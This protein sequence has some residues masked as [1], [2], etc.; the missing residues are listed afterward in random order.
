MD[1]AQCGAELI[2]YA[3]FYDVAFSKDT[4]SFIDIGDEVTLTGGLTITYYSALIIIGITF[5]RSY[6]SR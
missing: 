3:P 4:D 1:V 5:P 2:V 6:N